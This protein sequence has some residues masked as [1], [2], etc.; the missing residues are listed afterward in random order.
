MW[1]VHISMNN[2]HLVCS[3]IL[4]S[5]AVSE[6]ILGGVKNLKSKKFLLIV[7]KHKQLNI[8]KINVFYNK[9]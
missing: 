6:K 4:L 9:N 3:D 2:Y 5:V 8:L 7:L 1:A